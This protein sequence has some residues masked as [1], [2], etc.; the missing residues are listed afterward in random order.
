M[1]NKDQRWDSNDAC[2]FFFFFETDSQLNE[3]Y[4]GELDPNFG[5]IYKNVTAMMSELCGWFCEC[6][7]KKY[8]IRL[9]SYIFKKVEKKEF[10]GKLLT[11]SVLKKLSFI[12][13][14]V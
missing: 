12:D 9:V 7:A 11:I 14:E 8:S 4:Y 6:F 3:V 1:M 10:L 2:E 5:E 13:I